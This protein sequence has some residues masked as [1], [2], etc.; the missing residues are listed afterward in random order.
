M[1]MKMLNLKDS[2]NQLSFGNPR[3][4]DRVQNI[5]S[6]EG[7]GT[8]EQLCQKTK[9]ELQ[10][11]GKIGDVTISRIVS[12]LEKFGLHLGMSPLSA[13]PTTDAEP[14]Y[15]SLVKTSSIRVSVCLKIIRMISAS[16]TETWNQK[17]S[18]TKLSLKMVVNAAITSP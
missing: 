5:L 13:I 7:I 2:I 4:N 16:S 14:V 6:N 10:T 3:E 9:A 1:N 8:L 15:S 18:R 17:L 12:N 11:I